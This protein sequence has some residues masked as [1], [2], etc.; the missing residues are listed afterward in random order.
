[1]YVTAWNVSD[2]TIILM[3]L[4]RDSLFGYSIDKLGSEK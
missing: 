4:S 2:F 1:M 3:V